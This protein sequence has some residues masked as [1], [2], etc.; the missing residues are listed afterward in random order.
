MLRIGVTQRVDI[1]ESYGERRD[2]LDQKWAAFLEQ[3]HCLCIPLP[4]HAAIAQELLEALALDGL[5]LSGG[6]NLVLTPETKGVA[7]ERDAFEEVA[8]N[9]A[10]A[11]RIPVIAVCRG[12]QMLNHYCGGT[13]SPATDHVASRHALQHL[14]GVPALEGIAEVNSY[15][16]FAIAIEDL[17]ENLSPLALAPDGTVEAARHIELPWLG[18]MWHP[19]RE[20]PFR[21]EESR[22]FMSIFGPGQNN[23]E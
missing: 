15:H 18:I 6:N 21:I 2:C 4:N 9:W 22:L 16:D 19:E 12:M 5:I 23:H 14:Q 10:K 3:I 8:L 1:I 17:A 20:N 7:T 13:L 11:K